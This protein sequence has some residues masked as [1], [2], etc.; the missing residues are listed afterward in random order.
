MTSHEGVRVVFAGRSVPRVTNRKETVMTWAIVQWGPARFVPAEQLDEELVDA[1]PD[2]ELT[3]ALD[4]QGPRGCV[5]D[6][7]HPG[8]L[9]GFD[10]EPSACRY[11]HE[12]GLGDGPPPAT[13]PG[14][15]TGTSSS[16]TT[17]KLGPSWRRSSTTSRAAR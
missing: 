7:Q 6:P 17:W 13:R 14:S 5:V 4:N 8:R 3:T 12:H 9:V 1:P 2:L 11:V 10:D 15:S 16:P